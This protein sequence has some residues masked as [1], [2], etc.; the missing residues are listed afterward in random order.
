MFNK[1][2]SKKILDQVISDNQERDGCLL[3]YEKENNIS[4][5]MPIIVAGM[6]MQTFLN[7]IRG[8][9]DLEHKMFI[10]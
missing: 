9:T 4:H 5:A 10:V 2:N 8:K 7:Y 6:M 1:L 3:K